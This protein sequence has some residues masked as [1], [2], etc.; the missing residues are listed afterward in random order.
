MKIIEDI[1]EYEGISQVELARIIGITKST[2]SNYKRYDSTM[3]LK[4]INSVA[5]YFN[6]SI[7]YILGLSQQ[8]KYNIV[9]E[10]LINSK[11]GK[12]LQ[13][14]RKEFNIT[15]VSLADI[16]GTTHSTI[17]EYEKG[18]TLILTQFLYTICSKYKISADY[19]LGKTDEPKFLD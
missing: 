3:P 4:H 16:L 17:S 13:N 11:I 9:N 10:N 12:N 2:Y 8:Q 6:V 7:D 1:R 18:N 15:Q 19:L 14:F 5:N